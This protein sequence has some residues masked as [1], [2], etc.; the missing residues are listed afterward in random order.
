MKTIRYRKHKIEKVIYEDDKY[1]FVANYKT[2]LYNYIIDDTKLSFHDHIAMG[3][4]NDGTHDLLIVTLDGE[5]VELHSERKLINFGKA[6]DKYIDKEYDPIVYIN[7]KRFNCFAQL[8]GITTIVGMSGAGKT[9]SA[10]DMLPT[11]ANYFDKI[12]YINYELPDRDIISRLD[13][14]FPAGATRKKITEKLYIKDGIATNL[15]LPDYLD[16][17]EI[18]PDEKVVFIIDNVGSVV[19]QGNDVWNKQNEFLKELDTLVKANGWHALALTQMIKDHNLSIFDD[20]GNIKESITMSIMS[21]SI[22]LGNF[23]RSVLFT[24]Y[25]AESNEYLTKVLKRGTGKF[26]HEVEKEDLKHGYITTKW[27]L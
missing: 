13:D 3:A 11:Y 6:I 2:V 23:S 8:D 18:K 27:W 12:A 14:H 7:Y 25:N 22:M 16:A 9:F 20:N 24:A 10:I 17:M 4:F 19:G 5:F 15:N 1:I 21:G 26:Y